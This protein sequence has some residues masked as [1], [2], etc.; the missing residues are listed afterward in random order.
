MPIVVLDT[1]IFVRCLLNHRSRWG[2]LVFDYSSRYELATSP[3]VIAEIIEVLQ[4]PE[5]RGKFRTL[6][7]RDPR[8]VLDL[9]TQ[10]KLVELDAI[11]QVSRDPK[12]DMFLATAARAG[13]EYLVT[14]DNDLLVL[15]DYQGI[16]II[17]AEAFLRLLEAAE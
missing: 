1:V 9:L 11:A 4:R 3:A 12:D 17:T 8:R 7:E 5:L 14:E 2:R 16:K 10:A 15:K 13:A 6:A